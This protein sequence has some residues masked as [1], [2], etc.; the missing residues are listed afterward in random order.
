MNDRQYLEPS[1]LRIGDGP[2]HTKS[3]G[4]TKIETLLQN[5]KEEN[6]ASLQLQQLEIWFMIGLQLS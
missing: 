1:L 2:I 4:A 3:K 6:F 5:G